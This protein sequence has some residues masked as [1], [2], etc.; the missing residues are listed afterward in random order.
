MRVDNMLASNEALGLALCLVLAVIAL[1]NRGFL[2]EIFNDPDRLW[3]I[4]PRVALIETAVLVVWT[5]LFDNWR[6]VIGLPYRL[7]QKWPSQRVE[8]NPPSDDVRTVTMILLAVSLVLVACVVAR[9]VGG[10]I[11]QILL[12]MAA[13]TFWAPIFAIRQRFDVNLSLGFDGSITSPVNVVGY[14]LWVLMAWSL[15]II[16]IMLTYVLLLSL[17]AIPVTILLEI[18]RLRQPKVT[19]EADSFFASLQERTSS[20]RQA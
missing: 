8:Y 11:I 16:V 3:R 14:L 20:S 9:H 13:V 7:S 15:D 1:K 17:V 18:T 6:Q 2:R 5:S 10:V 12:F 4:I 19:K